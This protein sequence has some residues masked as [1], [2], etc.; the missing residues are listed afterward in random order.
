M[1]FTDCP[2][3][4]TVEILT[5]S[6]SWEAARNQITAPPTCVPNDVLT[7]R[8]DPV[9]TQKLRLVLSRNKQANRFVGMTEVEIWAPWPQVTEDGVYEAEDGYILQANIHDA[10]TASGGS[11]VGQIDASEASVEFTGVWVEESKEYEVR[12]YYSNGI[13]EDATMTVS[14]N[15]VHTQTTTFL[16]TINGWGQ[17]DSN[18]YVSLQIPLLR[19]NNAIIFKHG[20]NFVELDKIKVF[21]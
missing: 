15:N 21:T 18:T 4:V 3:N 2:T 16:P 17:F 7:V 20:T 9:K 14:A 13:P 10:N 12:V 11:Y 5:S 1:Y 8:F 6:G 19:G